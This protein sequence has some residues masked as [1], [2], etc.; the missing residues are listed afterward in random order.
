MSIFD[1]QISKE[2]KRE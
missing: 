1:E 2:F